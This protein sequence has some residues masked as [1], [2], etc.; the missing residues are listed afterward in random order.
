MNWS[1]CSSCSS[2]K[3]ERPIRKIQFTNPLINLRCFQHYYRRK[4]TYK[5]RPTHAFIL[6]TYIA[7]LQETTTQRRIYIHAYIRADIHPCI[8]TDL[9]SYTNRQTDKQLNMHKYI[10]LHTRVRAGAHTYIR[11]H[12]S[13]SVW[14]EL[15][16]DLL[17]L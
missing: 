1:L 17:L 15:P 8:H 16:L 7:H 5:C 11:T 9:H 4:E 3:A 10:N 13:N 2:S 14:N 12:V 6:E